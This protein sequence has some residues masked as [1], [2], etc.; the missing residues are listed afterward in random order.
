MP[1][2]ET[3]RLKHI[4]YSSRPV[5]FEEKTV[6]QILSSSRKNNPSVEV[7]GLLIYSADLYLQLLEGPTNAVEQTFNMIKNDARHDNVQIL[8]ESS[9]DRRIFAS[10][11][12]RPQDLKLMMWDEDDINNGLVEN[13][14]PSQAFNVFNNL[15]REFDQFIYVHEA[16][17]SEFQR[18]KEGIDRSP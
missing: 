5:G 8:K 7:T 16:E 14:S 1:Q 2:Q 18:S 12:M 11:T 9:T 13:L 4:I 17:W 3:T 15:S 10:W 6:E